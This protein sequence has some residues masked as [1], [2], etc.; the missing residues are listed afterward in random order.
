LGAFLEERVSIE[1]LGCVKMDFSTF[2][3]FSMS[4]MLKRPTLVSSSQHRLHESAVSAGTGLSET[5]LGPG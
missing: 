3:F 4:S 5:L 2:S 1:K